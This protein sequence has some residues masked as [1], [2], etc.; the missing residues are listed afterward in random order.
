M[1]FGISSACFYPLETEKSFRMIG[2]MGIK[3]AEIF[4][5]SFS[6]M[7]GEIFREILNIK[8]SYGIGVTSIHPCTSCCEPVFLFSDYERRFYDLLEIYKRFFQTC[9]ELDADTLVIHGMR[10]HMQIPHEKYFE[11]F[12]KLCEA[13]KEFGV[14]VSQENVQ[15]HVS[16]DVPFLKDMKEYLKDDFHLVFDVKQMR[17]CNYNEDDFLNVFIDDIVHVHISDSL[18]EK[19]CLPPGEGNYDL[20]GFLK[21][22][23]NSS[24]DGTCLIELYRSGYEEYSQLKRSYEYLCSLI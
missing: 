4:M 13:G 11:R 19:D 8:E 5:N 24:F 7:S 10:T 17:R 12:A 6:E 1:D 9:A 3:K 23:R 15:C 16:G 18:P 14:K 21:K 20:K 22:L 2:E